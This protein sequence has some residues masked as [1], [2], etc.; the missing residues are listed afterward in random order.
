MSVRSSR[1]RSMATSAARRRR[2]AAVALAIAA[3]LLAVVAFLR[4]RRKPRFHSLPLDPR[5]LAV[6]G[7]G[8]GDW[9]P[10]KALSGVPREGTPGTGSPVGRRAADA[11]QTPLAAE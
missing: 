4:R 5:S 8:V 3:S 10:S 1:F 7:W 9:P 11:P 6:L 2:D